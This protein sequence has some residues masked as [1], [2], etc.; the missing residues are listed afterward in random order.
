ME[1]DKKTINEILPSTD[2]NLIP[3]E[4]DQQAEDIANALD[5]DETNMEFSIPT[6]KYTE[7]L[8]KLVFP[9]KLLN[10]VQ[11]KL[12][13][14]KDRYEKRGKEYTESKEYQNLKKKSKVTKKISI[15]P[16][17]SYTNNEL[18]LRSK[19]IRFWVNN[20]KAIILMACTGHILDI[21]FVKDQES[22]PF[23]YEKFKEIFTHNPFTESTENIDEDED[24]ILD[25][26]DEEESDEDDDSDEEEEDDDSEENEDDDSDLDD[27]DIN[28]FSGRNIG[29]KFSTELKLPATQHKGRKKKNADD[30]ALVNRYLRFQLIKFFVKDHKEKIE[31]LICATDYDRE[32]QLIFG[33][34]MKYFGVDLSDRFRMKF[35][36][37]EDSVLKDAY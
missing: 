21:N 6:T 7:A 1:T 35:S 36:S 16:R 9:T 12:V 34:L 33:S 37:L 24:S 29:L 20:D 10:G 28:F 30:D 8:R 5:L 23:D 17:R 19:S 22:Y 2:Y 11:E 31:W 4:K 18:V 32:G 14:L 3:A 15:K 25:N 26:E 27:E 13:E